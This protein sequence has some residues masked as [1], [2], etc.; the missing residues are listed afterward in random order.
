MDWLG[1][2]KAEIK[3]GL[4][5]IFFTTNLE[6]QVQIQGR[7]GRN[8][9]KIVKAERIANGFRKGLPIYIIK[10][11]KPKR[12]EE[13]WDLAWLKE[14]QDVFPMELTNLPPKRELVHEIELIPGA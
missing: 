10:I 5:S 6:T 9:L 12:V 11:N 13:G 7:S 3:C 1:R 2:N 8:P 4:G 14:Y